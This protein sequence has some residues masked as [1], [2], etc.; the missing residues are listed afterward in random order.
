MKR[1]VMW[2]MKWKCSECGETFTVMGGGTLCPDCEIAQHGW[3]L[4]RVEQ[5]GVITVKL[6]RVLH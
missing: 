1:N 6:S 4:R 3:T 2:P 5:D